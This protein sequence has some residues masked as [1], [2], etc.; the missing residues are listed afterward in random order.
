MKPIFAGRNRD[1][2]VQE[3]VWTPSGERE[4]GMNSEIGTDVPMHTRIYKIGN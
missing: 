2:D 4:D 3:N 1:T